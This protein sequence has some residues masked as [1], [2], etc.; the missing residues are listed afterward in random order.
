MWR[1]GEECGVLYTEDRQ[2]LRQLCAMEK[3][4]VKREVDAATYTNAR[5][6]VIAWQVTFALPLWNRILRAI[7]WTVQKPIRRA[8][9]RQEAAIAQWRDERRPA[10]EAKPQR[11]GAR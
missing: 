10:L 7:G 4:P 6:K 5:G 2:V 9:Q 11:M 3:F 8:T 1:M